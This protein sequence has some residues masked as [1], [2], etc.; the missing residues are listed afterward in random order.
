ML[1][2]EDGQASP[3]VKQRRER[4]LR[5]Q[6]EGKMEAAIFQSQ[7]R[8]EASGGGWINHGSV[9]WPACAPVTNCPVMTERG[10]C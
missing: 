8:K 2:G 4:P 5:R 9:A 10:R 3:A 7:I 1:E 6:E